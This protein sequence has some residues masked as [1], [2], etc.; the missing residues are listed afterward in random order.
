MQLKYNI[1]Q[2]FKRSSKVLSNGIDMNLCMHQD[3]Y[4]YFFYSFFTSVNRC[5]QHDGMSY[6]NRRHMFVVTSA[7]KYFHPML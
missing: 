4:R 7:V 1:N 3:G 5:K 2:K 6:Q